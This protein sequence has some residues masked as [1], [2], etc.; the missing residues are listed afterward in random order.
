[1]GAAPRTEVPFIMCGPEVIFRVAPVTSRG[2]MFCGAMETGSWV[3]GPD[4]HPCFGSLGVLLDDALGYPVVHSRPADRWA[5][6][7]EI[8]VS[9][10][11]P[12]PADASTLR[13]ES[14]VITLGPAGGVGQV[15]VTDPAGQLVAFG[16][17]RLRWVSGTPAAL[18]GAGT[19]PRSPAPAPSGAPALQQ[20]GASIS[21]TAEGAVLTL[22]PQQALSNPMGALHGGI[23]F[24][25]SEMAGHAAVQRP[26]EGLTTASVHIAYVR[27]GTVTEPTAF[28]AVTLHRGRTLAVSQV[29]SR[30]AAGKTCTLATV[31]C[32]RTG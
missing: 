18:D 21:A 3:T 22:P 6:S 7:T 5:T 23:L 2:E 31:T 13:A 4:G 27:P 12:I 14:R 16:T 1:M 15:C 32:H 9:F 8:S 10:C 30:N 26:G 20:L 25:A 11:A 19:H 28:E 24:C 17:Q 29:T